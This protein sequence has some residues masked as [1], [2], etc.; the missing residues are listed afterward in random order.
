MDNRSV[1]AL[2]SPSLPHG[3]G[4]G[5]VWAGIYKPSSHLPAP[6]SLRYLIAD[7]WPAPHEPPEVV[8]EEEVVGATLEGL[9]R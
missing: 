7:R 1:S 9:I 2:S 8:T 3:V 5:L 6:C 4:F